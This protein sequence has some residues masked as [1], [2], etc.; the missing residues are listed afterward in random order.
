MS[1]P[2]F[3]RGGSY[4]CSG[5]KQC[6]AEVVAAEQAA[7]KVAGQARAA[8][9]VAAKAAAKSAAIAAKEDNCGSDGLADLDDDE[10]QEDAPA[11]AATQINPAALA[12]QQNDGSRNETL[13]YVENTM[14]FE[15]SDLKIHFLMIRNSEILIKYPYTLSYSGQ[16]Q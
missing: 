15:T 3:G 8:A 4:S 9:R 12:S 16:H 1:S 7:A 14:Y 13:N 10:G 11:A 2:H 5:C 6:S